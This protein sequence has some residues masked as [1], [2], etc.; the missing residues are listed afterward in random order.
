M[1][2]KFLASNLRVFTKVFILHGILHLSF[3]LSMIIRESPST[4]KFLKPCR[5]AAR[6]PA[7]SAEASAHKMSDLP[8][9]LVEARI[10]V[11]LVFL[12]IKPADA[13]FEDMT[14]PSKLSFR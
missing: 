8:R 1:L 7:L 14:E 3:K 6:M 11:P 2:S 12:K 13:A 10:G 9:F 4:C 5:R